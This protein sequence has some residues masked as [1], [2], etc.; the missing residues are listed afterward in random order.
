LIY[1]AM[2]LACS[3][4]IDFGEETNNT[5]DLKQFTS[6][7]TTPVPT[8]TEIPS[9]VPTR[10]LTAWPTRTSTSVALIKPK[11]SGECSDSSNGRHQMTAYNY[12]GEEVTLDIR[13]PE[14]KVCIISLGQSKI[15]LLPGR[16]EILIYMCDEIVY[17]ESHV[18]NNMWRFDLRC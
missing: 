10:T 5:P 9:L 11:P 1:F 16:Y 15:F 2:T 8:G 4:S 17:S 6:Q 18:L 14:S 13:G 12:T 3:F 7:P